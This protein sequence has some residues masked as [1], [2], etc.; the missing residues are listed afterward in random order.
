MRRLG[1]SVDRDRLGA[2]GRMAETGAMD[3]TGVM[4]WMVVGGLGGEMA[5]GEPTE[6]MG[7]MVP[8]GA[9]G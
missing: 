1:P 5:A 8:M 7:A 6:E 4:D 9:T 3:A 2:M